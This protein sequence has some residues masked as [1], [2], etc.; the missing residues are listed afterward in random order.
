MLTFAG[1]LSLPATS[2][3]AASPATKPVLIDDLTS[4]PHTAVLTTEN[5]VDFAYQ[6]GAGILGG[7]RHTNSPTA[8]TR[9]PPR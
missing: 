6:G 8:S 5:A 2:S 4:D 9:G 7:V 1:L 3:Q